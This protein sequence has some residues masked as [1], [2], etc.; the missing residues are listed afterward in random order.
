MSVLARGMAL[1]P[2]ELPREFHSGLSPAVANKLNSSCPPIGAHSPE[3]HERIRAIL[4]QVVRTHVFCRSDQRERPS[5]GG[6]VG[7]LII[8]VPNNLVGH[9]FHVAG[10]FAHPAQCGAA[11]T[12]IGV[13]KPMRLY[14]V[15]VLSRQ[16]FNFSGYASTLS[17]EPGQRFSTTRKSTVSKRFW[18][19]F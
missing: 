3:S 6:L 11:I 7:H 10:S 18:R 17:A 12:D 9:L 4:R 16:S 15:V 19:L 13:G 8:Q 1:W 2:E 14:I 5:P